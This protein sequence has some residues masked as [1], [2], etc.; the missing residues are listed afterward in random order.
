MPIIPVEKQMTVLLL[1]TQRLIKSTE[2]TNDSL[3][4]S[5]LF[6]IETLTH[7]YE[8]INNSITHSLVGRSFQYLNSNVSFFYKCHVIFYVDVLYVVS[9]MTKN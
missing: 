9:K 4:S 6:S 3:C 8:P 5:K 1:M 2:L 7:K